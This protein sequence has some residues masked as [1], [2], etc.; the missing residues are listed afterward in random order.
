MNFD[1]KAEGV[2]GNPNVVCIFAVS[3]TLASTDS[4]LLLRP[5][6]SF[7]A[8]AYSTFPPCLQAF[9]VR[10]YGTE[11]AKHMS[12]EQTWTEHVFT[13]KVCGRIC[14][15]FDFLTLTSVSL[16]EVMQREAP[17]LVVSQEEN[18]VFSFLRIFTS[19]QNGSSL[20]HLWQQWA[21]LDSLTRRIIFKKEWSNTVLSLL[22]YS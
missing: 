1:R 10:S 18:G 9:G 6:S 3:C 7:L 20:L 14:S 17:R 22:Y 4:D 15:F 2:P 12:M 21:F 5:T 19:R 13:H 16:C 8:L 11:S